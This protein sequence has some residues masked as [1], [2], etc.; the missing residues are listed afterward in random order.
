MSHPLAHGSRIGLIAEGDPDLA[1]ATNL[2]V[3]LLRSDLK[4]LERDQRRLAPTPTLLCQAPAV[5]AALLESGCA[6]VVILWDSAPF[7]VQKSTPTEQVARFWSEVERL[8]QTLREQQRPLL[9]RD[10]LCPIPV[11]QE[12]ESWLLADERAL[13]TYLVSS[14]HPK[15]LSR[16]PLPEREPNP[17]K[18]LNRIFK[19]HRPQGYVDYDDARRLVMHIADIARLRR[20]SSFQ[21]LMENVDATD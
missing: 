7:G 17:K 16:V 9:R 2:I 19:Q 5:A 1:V 14:N 6:H 15:K 20:L 11:L 21:A 12:L 18:A 4:V 3:R 13:S 8:N 10:A